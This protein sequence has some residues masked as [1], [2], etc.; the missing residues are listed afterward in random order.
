MQLE[1][2]TFA[3]E[4]L[5]LLC[6]QDAAEMFLR[7][8]A[9]HL[10]AQIGSSES[11]EA[12]LNKIDSALSAGPM[13]GHLPFRG[14]LVRLNKARVNFKHFGQLPVRQDVAGF[15]MDLEG[16]FTNVSRDH[17]GVDFASVSLAGLVIHQ[18]TKNRLQSAEGALDVGEYQTAI[19]EAARAIKIYE[20]Y[21]D[22]PLYPRASW[23]RSL[24]T[25]GAGRVLGQPD[26]FRG[27]ELLS[28]YF[29]RL[30]AEV[31]D[32]DRQLKLLAWGINLAQ[33]RRFLALTPRVMMTHARTLILQRSIGEVPDE[34]PDAARFCVGFAVEA[35]LTMQE[36]RPPWPVFGD[37]VKKQDLGPAEWEVIRRAPIVVYPKEEGGS[38]EIIRTPELG[39]RLRREVRTGGREPYEGY[40]TVRQDEEPAY[41]EES[42]VKQPTE[43]DQTE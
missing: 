14:A 24:P 9:E 18:R 1:A 7:V 3:A 40:V 36:N 30:E 21:V 25:V 16:F 39:E 6:L 34:G 37:I 11:F 5:A 13:P 8:L 41:I 28:P 22:H 33:Y 26:S 4:G 15:A 10:H 35:V 2:P 20:V 29:D 12:L 19:H 42:A 32:H 17:L 23:R 27:L 38:P 43:T 31:L